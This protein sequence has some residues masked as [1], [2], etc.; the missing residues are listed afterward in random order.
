[1]VGLYKHITVEEGAAGMQDDVNVGLRSPLKLDSFSDI[2]AILDNPRSENRNLDAVMW[3]AG[4]WNCGV[5]F[6]RRQSDW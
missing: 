5:I 1:M 6:T 4:W 2:A 3:H